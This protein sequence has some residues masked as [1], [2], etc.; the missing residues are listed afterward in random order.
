M[1]SVAYGRL[2]RPGL[3]SLASAERA[4]LTGRYSDAVGFSK[5]A[6]K[7]VPHGSPSQLRAADIQR[8]AERALKKKKKRRG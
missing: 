4:L 5:R 8:S 6:A 2:G 7:L 1:L 3:S